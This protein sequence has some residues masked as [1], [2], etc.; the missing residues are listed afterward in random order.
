VVNPKTGGGG[1]VTPGEDEDNISFPAGGKNETGEDD[2]HAE[3]GDEAVVV[4]TEG[5]SQSEASAEGEN[6]GTQMQIAPLSMM[7]ASAVLAASHCNTA[8]E[9]NN[10]IF[11][12]F[13]VHLPD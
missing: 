1:L 2:A 6:S 4:D 8:R 12:Y 7:L 11:G 13:S 3:E 10:I 9:L 5:E